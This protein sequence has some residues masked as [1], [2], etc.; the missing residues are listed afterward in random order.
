MNNSRIAAN[1]KKHRDSKDLSKADLARLSGVPVSTINSIESKVIANPDAAT[2]QKIARA[3]HVR[4][5]D[6]LR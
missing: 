4:T 3:L 1:L 5:E 2:V 6:L